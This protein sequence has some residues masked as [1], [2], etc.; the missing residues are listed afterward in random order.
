MANIERAGIS[1]NITNEWLD[2]KIGIRI[3]VPM[4]IRWQVVRQQEITDAYVLCY[5]LPVIAG[6]PGRKILGSFHAARCSFTRKARDRKWCTGQSTTC[7]LQIL[8]GVE[9]CR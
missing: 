4:R 6:N 8:S 2:Q 5:R 3:P 9:S 7:D 1:F